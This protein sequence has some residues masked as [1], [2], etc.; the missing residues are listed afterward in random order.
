[1][2]RSRWLIVF[3]VL[4]ASA[5]ML[6]ACN[7][8]PK[9]EGIGNIS[10]VQGEGV[11]KR[12]D[13]TSKLSFDLPVRVND[14]IVTAAEARAELTF[15]DGTKL[16]IGEQ[17]QIKIDSFLFEEGKSGNRLSLNIAGPFRYISG[18]LGAGEG[19]AVSVKTPMATIGVRGTDFWGGPIDQQYS[20]FLIE[21]LVSVT[22]EGGEVVLTAPGTGVD[23]AGPN[24]PPGPIVQW[25][26]DKVD[27]AVATVTFP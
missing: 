19:S 8:S 9:P 26:Q 20:V 13:S 12:G 25:G 21:G 24:Q 27:R 14:D 1:M 16:T 4:A 7:D 5:A 3:A 6:S 23:L 2:R 15:V 11:L 10:R 18:K 17:S 22:T